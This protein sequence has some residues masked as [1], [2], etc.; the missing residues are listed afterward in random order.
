MSDFEKTFLSLRKES[1]SLTKT[2]L[3]ERS[4]LYRDALFNDG[5]WFRRPLELT[6]SRL[7]RIK[8]Q[9]KQSLNELESTTEKEGD[10]LKAFSRYEKASQELRQHQ[11]DNG[12]ERAKKYKELLGTDRQEEKE[13]TE[14]E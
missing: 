2:P 12:I 8:P 5:P 10:L 13:L 4:G 1:L 9:E 3:E 11:Q 7:S 14:T 6:T